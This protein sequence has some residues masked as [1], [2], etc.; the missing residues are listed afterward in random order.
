MTDDSKRRPTP[1]R[2]STSPS[3]ER[4]IQ[5]ELARALAHGWPDQYVNPALMV[6]L[7]EFVLRGYTP[8]HKV[9]ESP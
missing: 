6:N 8:D 2:A 4:V 9:D 7:P 1:S 5:P 3:T